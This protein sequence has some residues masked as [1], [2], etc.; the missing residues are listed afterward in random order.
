MTATRPGQFRSATASSGFS[1]IE[2]MIAITLGILLLIGLSALMAQQSS[3]RAEI[4]RAGRQVENGRYA[5]SILQDDIQEA[6]YYGQFGSLTGTLAAIPN[7]CETGSTAA[8][9][10]AISAALLTP[11]QVY[12][13]P[14]TVPAPLSGCLSNVNH[15]AGTDILVVRRVQG[16]DTLDS[17]AGSVTNRVYIQTTPVSLI[18]GIGG[19]TAAA[20][21]TLLK[22]DGATAAEL[23]R[24]VVRVYYVSPCDIPASG[25]DCS[26]AAD[27]GTPIPTLKRLELTENGGSGG[28]PGF[29][30]MP[31]VEGI[32]NIQ[33]DF[34]IDNVFPFDG[35]PDPQGASGALYLTAPATLADYANIVSVKIS[36]LTRNTEVVTGFSDSKTYQLGL[37]TVGPFSDGYKRHAYSAVVRAINSSGRRE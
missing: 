12:D 37:T 35:A 23:R 9:L 2:L 36:L 27:G 10:T 17:I 16:D 11:I 18:V 21:F 15:V 5:T 19:T 4:D 32:E 3:A 24:Y 34:G 33:Y 8:S 26:P 31:L 29:T 28:V 13:A 1:L 22:K 20:T 6:G 30:V 14:M 7:P 25:T